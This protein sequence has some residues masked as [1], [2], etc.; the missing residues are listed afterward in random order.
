M[1]SVEERDTVRDHVLHIAAS[2]ERGIAGALVGGL[3]DGGGDRW[4][5][6]D[7]T[8]G[9][10]EN[11]PVAD[12]LAETDAGASDGLVERPRRRSPSHP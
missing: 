3:A 5:D 10:A 2:D 7:L 12:V 8:F 9:V 6:L 1:F 4:S 11:V